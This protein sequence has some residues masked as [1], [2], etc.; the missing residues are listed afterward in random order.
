MRRAA[1]PHCP[2]VAGAL[3]GARGRRASAHRLPIRRRP[4]GPSRPEMSKSVT[5]AF[6]RA[7]RMNEN[8]GIMRLYFVRMRAVR[9][10]VTDLDIH[11]SFWARAQ[12]AGGA[13]WV[14]R[15]QMEPRSIRRSGGHE[16][17]SR[18]KGNV[19][20]TVDSPRGRARAAWA[21]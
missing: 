19:A 9:A 14:H 4:Q 8:L 6:R 17:D 18:A 16:R 1:A 5:K 3:V 15:C 12:D 10:F 21:C 20:K 2:G 13:R 11:D 7:G